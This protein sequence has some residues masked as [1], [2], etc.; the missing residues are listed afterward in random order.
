M[1][2]ARADAQVRFDNV[3]L[4]LPLKAENAAPSAPAPPAELPQ[5]PGGPE[6]APPPSLPP[7]L[8]KYASFSRRLNLRARTLKV[9]IYAAR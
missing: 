2:S 1:G 5:A 3:Q 4:T 6:S 9:V 7:P 8:P